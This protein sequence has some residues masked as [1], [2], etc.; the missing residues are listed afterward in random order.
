MIMVQLRVDLVRR[1]IKHTIASQAP[2]KNLGILLSVESQTG[3]FDERQNSRF[4]QR[5]ARVI[6][7]TSSLRVGRLPLGFSASMKAFHPSEWLASQNIHKAK[8]GF[9]QDPC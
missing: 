2:Q 6:H 9:E 1:S 8:A 3:L 4:L 7:K 5:L